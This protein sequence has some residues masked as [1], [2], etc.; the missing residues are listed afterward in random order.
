MMCKM[1]WGYQELERGKGKIWCMSCSRGSQTG[2]GV[3]HRDVT[4]AP[5]PHAELT[6][7]HRG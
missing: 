1:V 2:H 4:T 6:P 3:C 7:A 5:H